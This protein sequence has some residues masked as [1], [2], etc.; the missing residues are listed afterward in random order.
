LVGEV[1]AGWK[2]QENK[3]SGQWG[4][5]QQLGGN[6]GDFLQQNVEVSDVDYHAQVDEALEGLAGGVVELEEEKN[7]GRDLEDVVD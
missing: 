5:G 6:G 4:I 3:A 1:K 2:L 7:T